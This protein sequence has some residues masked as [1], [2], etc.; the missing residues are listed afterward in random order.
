MYF[1]SNGQRLVTLSR[2]QKFRNSFRLAAPAKA[3]KKKKLAA[4]AKLL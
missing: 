4:P 2:L 3:R 1:K